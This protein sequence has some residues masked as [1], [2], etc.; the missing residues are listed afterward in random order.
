MRRHFRSSSLLLPAMAVALT[1]APLPGQTAHA[2]EPATEAQRG[3]DVTQYA[4]EDDAVL[5]DTVGPALEVLHARR[6]PGRESL[7]RARTQFVSELLKS[8]EQL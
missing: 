5:G 6:R 3:A 4:F 8:V 7:V 1:L 2:E